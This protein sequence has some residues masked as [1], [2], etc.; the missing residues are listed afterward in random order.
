MRRTM[1]ALVA[2]AGLACASPAIGATTLLRLDGIGPLKLGMT[3]TAAVQTG[4]LASRHTGCP[5]GGPPLPIGYRL[6]GP[7]AP[8]G[9]SG[10]AEFDQGRLRVL[11]FTR[12]VRTAAGVV[13]GRT[14]TS[15]MVADYRRAGFVATAQF[16]STFQGT[17]VN[18]RRRGHSASVIGGFATH[19][20][21]TTLA[22]PAVAVCE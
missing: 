13:V 14:T 22:I 1:V 18:V 21:I 10:N 16:D 11:S 20:K 2:V 7:N 4:W 3:R 12:G 5:L 15:Q 19:T 6:T 17:F 8:P 9:T